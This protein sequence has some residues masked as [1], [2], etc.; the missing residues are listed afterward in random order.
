MAAE[1]DLTPYFPPLG[2][3][4]RLM[5]GRTDDAE[6]VHGA[7]GHMQRQLTQDRGAAAGRGPQAGQALR[8][9][10]GERVGCAPRS[11]PPA[12]A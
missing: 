2:T 3:E 7:E 1:H 10:S 6:A 5:K 12:G 9:V 11:P 8:L 4:V